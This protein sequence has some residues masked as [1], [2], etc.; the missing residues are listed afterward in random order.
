MTKAIKIAGFLIDNEESPGNLPLD[1][2][3]FHYSFTYVSEFAELR[4][5]R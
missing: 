2:L 3:D 4:N 5:R 1:F